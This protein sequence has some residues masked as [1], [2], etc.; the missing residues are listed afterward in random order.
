MH[1][2]LIH[3]KH[4]AIDLC[5]LHDVTCCTGECYK[6]SHFQC[7]H[8]SDPIIASYWKSRPL[9]HDIEQVEKYIAYIGA[10]ELDSLI[11]EKIVTS[12]EAR[13]MKGHLDIILQIYINEFSYN[14]YVIN[15]KETTL[16]ATES[17]NILQEE[18]DENI[19][20]EEEVYEEEKEED[21]S[22]GM[23]WNL[24]MMIVTLK[25]KTQL[26]F[27]KLHTLFLRNF[28]TMRT[29]LMMMNL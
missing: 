24:S 2:L 5:E 11:N 10:H 7:K 21:L 6:H 12:H 9:C 18:D 16:A 19:S 25:L 17:T 26:P 8:N 27:I 14:A 28:G 4:F 29:L 13:V 23:F 22:L 3:I 1:E 15:Y 20:L